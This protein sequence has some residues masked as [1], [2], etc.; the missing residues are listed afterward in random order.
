MKSKENTEATTTVNKSSLQSAS[1]NNN[2]KS[3][4]AYGAGE[5]VV[6]THNPKRYKNSHYSSE[7]DDYNYDRSVNYNQD[8]YTLFLGGNNNY[9]SN[10]HRVRNPF[11]RNSSNS[12]RYYFKESRAHLLMIIYTFYIIYSFVSIV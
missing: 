12:D 2:R 4:G 3:G 10:V 11:R 8:N 9:N 5:D 6:D 1:S 7:S